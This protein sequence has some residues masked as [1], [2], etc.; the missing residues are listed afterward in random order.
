MVDLIVINHLLLLGNLITQS[1]G[2]VAV[3][4]ILF[5]VA[6]GFVAI[7]QGIS[8]VGGFLGHLAPSP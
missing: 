4:L 6:P 5:N 7:R 2:P 1:I 8:D 3:A